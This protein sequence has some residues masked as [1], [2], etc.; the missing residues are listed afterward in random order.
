VLTDAVRWKLGLA[1]EQR[2]YRDS[3]SVLIRIAERR[4]RP[5]GPYGGPRRKAI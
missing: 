1:R 5:S 3:E 2:S 4:F